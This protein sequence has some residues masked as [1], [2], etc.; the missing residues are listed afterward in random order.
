[1]IQATVAAVVTAHPGA[2]SIGILGTSGTRQARLY[3]AAA[4]LAGLSVVQ[5][6]SQDQAAKVDKAIRLVKS[7][8]DLALAEQLVQSAAELLQLRGADLAIAA[9]TEI[10]VVVKLACQV[11]PVVDSV[12]ALVAACLREFGLEGS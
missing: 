5:V 6:S 10:P 1:M 3:E 9:C 8:G 11:L 12:D 2:R 4:A 7:G